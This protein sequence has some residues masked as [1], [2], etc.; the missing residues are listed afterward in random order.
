M[1]SSAAIVVPA[2]AATLAWWATR[3]W[4]YD[5]YYLVGP[6]RVPLVLEYILG[7]A[8]VLSAL[9]VIARPSVGRGGHGISPLTVCLL[10]AA[11]IVAAVAWRTM[12]VPAGGAN[13][14]GGMAATMAP[15]LIAGLLVAAAF[16]ER[17]SR[18]DRIP[19][20]WL[21]VSAAATTAPLLVFSALSLTWV[22]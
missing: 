9:I 13:I 16:A 1:R 20:F 5:D 18:E 15:V 6:Y 17:H 8:A 11:G 12:T 22:A 2:A 4:G 19:R 21:W 7:G 14:G 3:D 10:V